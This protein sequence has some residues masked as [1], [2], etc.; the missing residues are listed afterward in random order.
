MPHIARAQQFRIDSINRL[1]DWLT[2]VP[3][4]TFIQHAMITACERVRPWGRLM[5][6]L[7]R[8]KAGAKAKFYLISFPCSL[9]FF[10]LSRSL[11]LGANGPL[12]N[13]KP[14]VKCGGALVPD[15][16]LQPKIIFFFLLIVAKLPTF[17][18]FKQIA[19]MILSPV[20]ETFTI[21]VKTSHKQT[22][23]LNGTEWS[24]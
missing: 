15:Q 18:L 4:W 8:T 10:S 6:H 23:K 13:A 1:I 16:W 12:L 22:N 2:A 3:F 20:T 24:K 11:R 9:I 17:P 14:T 19:G 7:H 21:Q 5:V